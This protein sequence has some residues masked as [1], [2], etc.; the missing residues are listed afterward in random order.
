[1]EWYKSKGLVI[2][3]DKHPV[4]LER[5]VYPNCAKE[6]KKDILKKPYK[7][8]EDLGI[9]VFY[10]QQLYSFMIPKGYLFDGASIPR[11]FWRLIG[12]NTDNSF[13]IA[14]MVHDFMCENHGV[15]NNDRYLST[16]IFNA[17][18]EVGGVCGVKRWLMKHSVDNFQK[19]CA[20]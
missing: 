18:L 10:K 11:V 20:W 13:L 14:A 16:L 1:M 8:V 2:N 7:N 6:E 15:V 4:V 3:F 19:F 5:Y 12:A 17:L 9:E